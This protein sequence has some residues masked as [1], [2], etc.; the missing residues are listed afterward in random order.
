[1]DL[2]ALSSNGIMLIRHFRPVSL[3]GAIKG[4]LDLFLGGGSLK[5]HL[6][7]DQILPYDEAIFDQ[8]RK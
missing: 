8:A 2:R 3:R 6:A 1:M 4:Q 7:P 5:I